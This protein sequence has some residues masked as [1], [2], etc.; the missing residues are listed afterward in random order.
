LN[1]IALEMV[2]DDLADDGFRLKFTSTAGVVPA[3]SIS[4]RTN[5]AVPEPSAWPMMLLGFAL[6]GYAGLCRSAKFAAF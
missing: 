2:S 4:A 6:L 1:T 3:P 5:C